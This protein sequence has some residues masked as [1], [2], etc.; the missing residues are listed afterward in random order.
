MAATAEPDIDI[1]TEIFANIDLSDKV[2]CSYTDCEQEATHMLQC[3]EDSSCET[4]CREHTEE[5]VMTKLLMPDF[6]IIFD[7]TC[8]HTPK[9]GD[10]EILPLAK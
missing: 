9:M 10:C 7:N 8:G 6:Q 3:P 5:A 4:M 2:D 1:A